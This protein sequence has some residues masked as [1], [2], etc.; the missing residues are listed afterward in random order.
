MNIQNNVLFKAVLLNPV[1]KGSKLEDINS[2][3]IAKSRCRRFSISWS[4]N[5]EYV[6][7][8]RIFS[9]KIRNPLV[10]NISCIFYVL[11]IN[12]LTL[13]VFSDSDFFL[14]SVFPVMCLLT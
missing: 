12:L 3:F 9:F 5:I 7:T 13:Y 2:G 1:C 10:N 14:L 11:S 6:I 8:Q 4:T